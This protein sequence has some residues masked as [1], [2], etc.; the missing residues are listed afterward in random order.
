M[1]RCARLSAQHN[2][3]LTSSFSSFT[4]SSASSSAFYD[5]NSTVPNNEAMITDTGSSSITNATS[6]S[7]LTCTNTGL[8]NV[9]IESTITNNT[10]NVDSELINTDLTTTD[11]AN[12]RSTSLDNN[13][14][15]IANTESISVDSESTIANTGLICN[16]DST[17]KDELTNAIESTV[18]NN[19][20][21]AVTSADTSDK[22]EDVLISKHSTNVSCGDNNTLNKK[23][24]HS[25]RGSVGVTANN[26]KTKDSSIN[27][28]YSTYEYS[29]AQRLSLYFESVTSKDVPSLEKILLKLPD[30]ITK[31]LCH[32]LC[33]CKK[34]APIVHR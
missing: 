16:V 34:C 25:T 24:V 30:D 31:I 9:D 3:S 11:I 10:A 15:T 2:Q 7:P 21:I 18:V 14:L 29:R 8:T 17:A 26:N 27:D 22:E 28:E 12:T 1:I 23:G 4:S 33:S 32:P 5:T 19:D 6:G 13:K 20:S